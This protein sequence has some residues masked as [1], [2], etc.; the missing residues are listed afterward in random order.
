MVWKPANVQL[1]NVKGKNA[2]SYFSAKAI[3]DSEA[4]TQV[5]AWEIL[6]AYKSAMV[7]AGGGHVLGRMASPQN[8]LAKLFD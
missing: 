6:G 8:S 1:K 2:A 4:V 5:G 7:K 3:D